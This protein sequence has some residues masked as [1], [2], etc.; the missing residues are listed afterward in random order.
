MFMLHTACGTA[1]VLGGGVVPRVSKPF[2]LRTL[3]VRGRV[4]R[5]EWSWVW[6]SRCCGPLQCAH[7][8]AEVLQCR[9]MLLEGTEL[10]E[11][12]PQPPHAASGCLRAP[13]LKVGPPSVLWPLSP[14]ETC[15]L[16]LGA[17]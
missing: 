13:L 8:P 2:L 9:P 5:E 3:R 12:A 1:E 16:L 14:G 4:A 17:W 7:V 6:G 10:V 15:F 11:G